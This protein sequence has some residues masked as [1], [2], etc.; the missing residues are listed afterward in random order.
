[1]GS[2]SVEIRGV[3]N[4]QQNNSYLIP[5]LLFKYCFM[6]KT[7]WTDS[8]DKIED[9]IVD[10]ELSLY[11]YFLCLICRDKYYIECKEN[12]KGREKKRTIES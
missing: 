4:K 3:D 8:N 1:M 6:F 11:D 5:F 2:S 12:L 7:L 10:F 9:I